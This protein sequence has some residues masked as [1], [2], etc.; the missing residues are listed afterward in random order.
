MGGCATKPN[1]I[2]ED[3]PEEKPGSPRQQP[4]PAQAP[5]PEGVSAD[6]ANKADAEKKEEPPL[7]D[8]AQPTSNEPKDADEKAT[9]SSTAAATNN[10]VSDQVTAPK[11]ESVDSE[12]KA[13]E[14]NHAVE[15]KPGAE[16]ANSCPVPK[17]DSEKVPEAGKQNNQE[18]AVES[19][20][21]SN[22]PN[23]EKKGV[24]M[25]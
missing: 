4:Q 24:E 5:P 12:K 22:A 14:A 3:M 8:L 15:E 25:L 17:L 20:Q 11:P 21:P 7:V 18:G 23:S 2:L 9:E 16:D 19:Q 1:S 13:P 10:V 6:D